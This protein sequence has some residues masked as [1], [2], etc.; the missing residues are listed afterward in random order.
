MTPDQVV[1]RTRSHYVFINFMHMIVAFRASECQIKKKLPK[2]LYFLKK[3]F[4]ISG[5]IKMFLSCFR[6]VVPNE[7]GSFFWQKL[8]LGKSARRHLAPLINTSGRVLQILCATWP[9]RL[10]SGGLGWTI[11][12]FNQKVQTMLPGTLALVYHVRASKASSTNIKIYWKN[13]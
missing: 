3:K 5:E 12:R 1:P 10:E 8:G 11:Y 9:P 6:T 4:K 7:K 2:K 13:T